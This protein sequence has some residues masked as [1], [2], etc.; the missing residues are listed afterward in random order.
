MSNKYLKK[1]DLSRER[2]IL[3][4]FMDFSLSKKSHCVFMDNALIMNV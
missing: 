2:M 1:Q 3:F 4:L